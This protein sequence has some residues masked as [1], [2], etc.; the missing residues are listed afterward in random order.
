MPDSKPCPGC[1]SRLHWKEENG[2]RLLYIEWLE[3]QEAEGDE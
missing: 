1:S 2:D 3:A